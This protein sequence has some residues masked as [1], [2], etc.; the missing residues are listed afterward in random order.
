MPEPQQ[1]RD[2]ALL[3]KQQLAARL[4]ADSTRLV[5]D[6]VATRKIPVIRLGHRTVRFLWEDVCEALK[7]LTV[8][9]RD[10]SKR[11]GTA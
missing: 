6:L 10:N 4:G 1:L 3:T 5:D 2:T 9:P 7:A 8:W 11:R